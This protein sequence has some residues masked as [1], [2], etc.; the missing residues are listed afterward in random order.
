MNWKNMTT[1]SK[2][3]IANG[4]AF[5]SDE[6]I[7]YVTF[8]SNEAWFHLS[9][10]INSHNSN[11]WPAFNVH[12]IMETP[13]LNQKDGVLCTLSQNW[14][15]GPILFED[16]IISDHHCQLIMYSSISLLN[17]NIACG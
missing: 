6:Y 12:E 10:Y 16:T 8:S 3:N 13:L 14:A 17:E 2:C 15:I 11:V 1:P 5:P 7:Q 4:L 9:G